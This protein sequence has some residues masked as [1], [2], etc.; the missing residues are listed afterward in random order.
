MVVEHRAS[1]FAAVLIVN[2]TTSYCPCNHFFPLV[3]Q[4]TTLSRVLVPPITLPSSEQTT[5]CRKLPLRMNAHISKPEGSL[6]KLGLSSNATD[7]GSTSEDISNEPIVSPPSQ[8][9]DHQQPRRS[10]LRSADRRRSS[11]RSVCFSTVQTRVFEVIEVDEQHKLDGLSVARSQA[12]DAVEKKA[13]LDDGD[14]EL[15]TLCKRHTLRWRFSDR[16]SD[17]ETHESSK[18]V[19]DEL[20]K[21]RSSK[22][23]RKIHT[24]ITEQEKKERELDGQEKEKK[25]F[26][27]KVLQQLWSG[28]KVTLSQTAYVLSPI[29]KM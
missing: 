27:S 11:T 6:R 15:E 26:K 28:F 9:L 23:T 14:D 17:I 29:Q 24:H 18:L 4:D 22:Y 1:G 20:G 21:E 8:I 19:M 7:E 5:R 12:L 13:A 3:K 2:C 16:M 25:G 10:S